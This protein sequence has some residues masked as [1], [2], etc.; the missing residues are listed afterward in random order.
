MTTEELRAAFLTERLMEADGVRLVYTHYD[1][2]I[3]G[4]V[5]PVERRLA[6]DTPSRN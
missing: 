4:G 2:V 1:R 3:I 5:Q 6:L